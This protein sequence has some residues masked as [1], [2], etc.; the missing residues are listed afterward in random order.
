MQFGVAVVALILT[1]ICL[2]MRGNKKPER[3]VACG[4]LSAVRVYP[5]KSGRGID[6]PCATVDVTGGF[7]GDRRWMVVDAARGSMVTGRQKPE[8]L[9]VEVVGPSTWAEGE[10]LSV[11]APTMPK[12]LT[13]A[14]G[15]LSPAPNHSVETEVRV[16]DDRMQG[17]DCG[18]EAAA[19]FSAY[20][21]SPCR[22][23]TAGPSY[24]RRCAPK[25][26]PPALRTWLGA[27]P[28]V[29][30]ADG[31]PYLLIGEESLRYLN[32]RL[33]K[34]S[35]PAV[36]MNRFR[37]NM[38]VKGVPAFDEDCWRVIRIGEVVFHV[39]KPCMRCKMTTIDP[40]TGTID[41]RAV[42]D[43][44]P[45]SELARF[46]Q[47]GDKVLFGQNLV[48]ASTGQVRPGDELVVLER[49]PRNVPDDCLPN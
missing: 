39:V 29:S 18:D 36:E 14:L 13:V 10:E 25:Y 8:L 15:P 31:F 2:S 9:L 44:Q 5:L 3:G 34:A 16:W 21:D 37:P 46:R 33:A 1:A 43:V 19:W 28:P 30:F 45:L 27:T 47:D 20:L 49:G 26:T 23:V 35:E 24:N 42:A 11:K 12:P 6:V 22:L 41:P 38:V 40:A 48:A 32:D 7:S 4:A 17:S